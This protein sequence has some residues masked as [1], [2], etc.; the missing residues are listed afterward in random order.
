MGGGG[1]GHRCL[2]LDVAS[3]WRHRALG[4]RYVDSLCLC[5]CVSASVRARVCTLIEIT[6][7]CRIWPI[8]GATGGPLKGR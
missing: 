4:E 8:G 2:V 6:W 5:Q 3:R 1:H 7:W